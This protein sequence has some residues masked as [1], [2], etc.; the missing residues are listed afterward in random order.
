MTAVNLANALKHVEVD[1]PADRYCHRPFA[2]VL[3]R[4][5]LALPKMV[6]PTPTAITVMSL[7][8]GW[9]AAA[10]MWDGLAFGTVSWNG[11]AS[12]MIFDYGRST[13]LLAAG[14]L[15]FTSIVLDCADGQLARL[16]G[17]TSQIGR[18]I[19]GIAD[20]LV[21]SAYC[22]VTCV[23]H[24][25]S[26]GLYG[27]LLAVVSCISLQQHV[28]YYD[29]ARIAFELRFQ[30]KSLADVRK[31]IAANGLDRSAILEQYAAASDVYQKACYG[32][33]MW[34]QGALK[35]ERVCE[36]A[37]RCW[38]DRGSDAPAVGRT[39]AIV[40]MRLATFQGTGTHIF[41]WYLSMLFAAEYPQAPTLFLL[42][43]MTVSNAFHVTVWK[44]C[45][46]ANLLQE[47]FFEVSSAIPFV[48]VALC[49]Y[50]FAC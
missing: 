3:V 40:A 45:T 22:C 38:R 29:K 8:V 14:A 11:D 28:L 23:T 27:L 9:L 24:G 48:I 16:T 5:L 1:E 12:D 37:L 35:P 39:E 42:F 50:F 30:A 49:L 44:H 47:P 4:A 43:N 2:H 13:S 19:D 33:A 34:Y 32:L 31:R 10:F 6:V 26:R 18:F 46:Q 21:I 41:L 15:M 36:D 7:L 20:M 17:Q 25:R